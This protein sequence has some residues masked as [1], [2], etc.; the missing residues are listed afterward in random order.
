MR[1]APCASSPRELRLD[2]SGAARRLSGAHHDQLNTMDTTTRSGDIDRLN[3]FLR[4]EIAAVETYD[5]VIARAT[6]SRLLT[7]LRDARASHA[8][9]VELLRS[10]ITEQGGEPA[11]G[12]GAWGVF[13]RAVEGGALEIGMG[14]AIGVLE[15]G[16][17][18]GLADYRDDL[19]DLS[20]EVQRLVSDRLLPD[21]Q[22]THDML[23]TLKA[24]M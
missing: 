22:R 10:S 19:A 2:G 21:Q 20:P 13:A 5:R 3:S 23:S 12:S 24:S 14:T 9:R 11:R 1:D 15:E 7:T 6:D 17:D 16:E 8:R 18:R 4:G